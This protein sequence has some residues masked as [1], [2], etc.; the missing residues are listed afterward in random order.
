M[1]IMV[2]ASPNVREAPCFP[3]FFDK[4]YHWTLVFSDEVTIISI[5]VNE[6]SRKG[7]RNTGTETMQGDQGSH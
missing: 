7:R 5:K 6:Y 1:E 3:S 4:A 2:M